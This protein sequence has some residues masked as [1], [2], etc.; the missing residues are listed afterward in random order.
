MKMKMMMNCNFCKPY[1]FG[2]CVYKQTNKQTFVNCKPNK[3]TRFTNRFTLESVCSKA[4]EILVNYV[5]SI[6]ILLVILMYNV[7][8]NTYMYIRVY[9]YA[10]ARE[11]LQIFKGHLG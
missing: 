6:L 4:F 5:N 9:I 1:H 7:Y 11:N 3:L 8:I 10:G 2:R